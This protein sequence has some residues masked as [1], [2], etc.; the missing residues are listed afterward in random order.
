MY[1]VEIQTQDLQ[2]RYMV[3]D[4]AGRFVE[5]I[6]RYLKHLD[7]IG[8]ACNTLRS[9]ATMLRLYWEYLSQQQIDWH[10]ITL[11]D[12]AQFVLWLKFPSGSLK[13]VYAQNLP[14]RS[15]PLFQSVSEIY[16]Q[17]ALLIYTLSNGCIISTCAEHMVFQLKTPEKYITG[18]GL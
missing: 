8:A 9:Y 15:A 14:A 5:P 6:V 4:D 18:S 13:V 1:V 17:P 16:F 2:D 11:D 7:R 12:L 3:I 10:D